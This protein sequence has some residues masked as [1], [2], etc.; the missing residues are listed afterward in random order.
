MKK[1][2]VIILFLLIPKL[3][4]AFEIPTDKNY[5]PERDSK[6]LN[7]L[8]NAKNEEYAP[9]KITRLD[10]KKMR[11]YKIEGNLW[12]NEQWAYIIKLKNQALIKQSCYIYLNVYDSAGFLLDKY[13]LFSGHLLPVEI[14]DKS[15]RFFIQLS[16]IDQ[17]DKADL[18]INCISIP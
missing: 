8:V 7:L 10:F 15:D 11:G 9:I 18:K 17:M 2:F 1:L 16:Y 14:K 3:I 12:N 13:L 6:I 4:Y 5:S